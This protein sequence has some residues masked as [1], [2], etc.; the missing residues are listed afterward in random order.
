MLSSLLMP[1]LA[2]LLELWQP[3]V[4][5]IWQVSA[6]APGFG[7]ALDL[8]T[9]ESRPACTNKGVHHCSQKR[10]AALTV[11]CRVCCSMS[12]LEFFTCVNW[13]RGSLSTQCT[14]CQTP[15]MTLLCRHPAIARD[16][17]NLDG[18]IVSGRGDGASR[19][20]TAECQPRSASSLV[21]L[22]NACLWAVQ[23]GVSLQS[24]VFSMA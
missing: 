9:F 8:G 7:Q 21:L 12:S 10:C 6:V 4:E 17:Y 11:C 22:D 18:G 5:N 23:E 15:S 2:M 1:G 20:S 13:G 24:P 14:D 3:F 19:A 16:L